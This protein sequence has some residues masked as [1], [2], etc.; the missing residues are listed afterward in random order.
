MLCAVLDNFV[1]HVPIC[2]YVR[3]LRRCQLPCLAG[4]CTLANV[5]R[6]MGNLVNI[7]GAGFSDTAI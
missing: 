6:Q 1:R 2:T 5:Q 4:R 7:D 3:T